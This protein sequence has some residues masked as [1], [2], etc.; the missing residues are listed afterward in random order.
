M[1]VL[2]VPYGDL[3]LW[4]AISAMLHRSLSHLKEGHRGAGAPG[5]P[6]AATPMGRERRREQKSKKDRDRMDRGGF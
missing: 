1:L 5:A 6:G 4:C 3:R 2:L